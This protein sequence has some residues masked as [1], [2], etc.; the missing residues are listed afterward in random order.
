MRIIISFLVALCM[1]TGFSQSLVQD[2]VL[3]K[4]QLPNGLT[5][6]IYPTNKVKGQAHFRLFVKVGSLQETEKQRGLAHFLEH[7][8]FNGTKHFKANELIEFLET[9]GSKFGHDVNAHTSFEETIY[10]LKVSTKNTSVIDSTLTIMSDWV[11]GMLLDSFE[12]E[13]ERGVVL[14]E[15]LSKQSPKNKKGQFFLQTLLN[16]SLY[17]QRTVIGDTTS[18]K[19]FKRKELKAFYQ[20]WYDPSLMAVAIAG[21]VDAEEVE[22]KIIKKFAKIPT[23]SPKP[24]LGEIASYTNDSLVIYKDDLTKKTQLSYIQLHEPLRDVNTQQAYKEYLMRVLINKLI[25]T[26]L[27]QLSF[28][29]N[30]YNNASINLN[31]F[32]NSKG[33]LLATI[34]LKPENALQG[35]RDFNKHFQ[36]I[37]QYGFTE[38]EIKKVTKTMLASFGAKAKE[39]KPVSASGMMG[40]MYEDFFNGNKIISLRDEY[41]LMKNCFSELTAAKV[42]VFLKKNETNSPFRYLLTTNEK[43]WDK[44]P[45]KGMLFKAIQEHKTIKVAPY[46]HHFKVPKKLI[47]QSI[48]PGEIKKIKNIPEI[49]AQEIHLT[50]GAT[51]IYKKSLKSKE[52][53]LLAGFKKGGLYAIDSTD[54]VSAQYAAPAIS[55]SGYGAFSR[56]ALSYYLSGNSAKV[57]FLIDKTRAGFFGSSKIKD[58]QTLFQLFYL[59]ATDPKIDSSAFKKLKDLSIERI[60][61]DEPSP[62]EV[63]QK[64]F[65]YLVRGKD[66]TTAKRTKAQVEEKLIKEKL[67]PIYKSFFANADG[68]VIT[69]ISDKELEV[70][71]PFIKT[72]IGGIPKGEVKN[73][74]KY[75]PR[76]LKKKNKSLV[77]YG[78]ESSK[79][80]YTA[81]HQQSKKVKNIAEVEIK[82]QILENVLKLELNKRLR[83][84]L[85]V[86]YG[87]RVSVSATQHP[88]PLSRQTIALVCKP[89]D[90]D[91]IKSEIA[92]IINEI[93]TGA[94]DI[95]M[96]MEKTKSN[97]ISKF[98]ISRQ[99][100]SFWTKSI[101]DYYFN[102]YSNWDFVTAYPQLVNN[103]S[104]KDIK[105]ITQTYF[106]KSPKIEAILYPK[107]QKN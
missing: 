61:E 13:K 46:E 58:L 81:I 88:K 11:N 89:A 49:D 93:A 94:L 20:K 14:S 35:I 107:N 95:E 82:N 69:L 15:W 47:T 45:S 4:K 21:D 17:S 8:A 90:V 31:N 18:L 50:N 9:K 68:F 98:N 103:I 80:I 27:A 87:V 96:H 39:N 40:Q 24:L 26:R 53:V 41:A 5:Y 106:L 73:A 37:F 36:Q 74:Y 84:E 34:D 30:E 64:K 75:Q 22:H 97:L 101:R 102:S 43:E 7:M 32:L 91:L 2:T 56:E 16:N 42:L 77:A 48:Q 1:A 83:E 104:K 57:Q 100:N 3:V 78:E 28:Q 70:F 38:L 10:K 23:Q 99:K 6:Y 60:V 79:A 71:L 92:E 62:K 85:G 51:V 63:F 52:S 105:K 72:Y 19:N 76:P 29:E 65:K 54:Y 33:V 59:K 66:Y 86:I 44:L 25:T 55:V 67:I 12:V